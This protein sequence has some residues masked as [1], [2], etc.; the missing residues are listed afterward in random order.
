MKSI[1][2]VSR[3]SHENAE[4]MRDCIDI[5][6]RW[7]C[8]WLI[9]AFLFLPIHVSAQQRSPVKVNEAELSRRAK[10]IDLIVETAESARTFEDF[11]YR[12]RMQALA[13]DALWQHDDVRARAIFRRAWDA[14][15]SYD[16]SEQEIEERESGV[17]S[18]LPITE[19]RDEVLTKV[20]ARDS[21][22]SEEFLRDLINEKKDENDSR[23]KL[24]NQRRTPWRD[25]SAEGQHRL[26]IAYALLNAGETVAAVRTATPL[27]SEGASADLITFLIVLSERDKEE[28]TSLYIRL[29]QRMNNDAQADAI[30]VLL[31]SAPVI[32][33]R[34][35]VT[36]DGQ[37]ALQFRTVPL[38]SPMTTPL[39]LTTPEA[40][41]LF[42]SL[43]ANILLRP[44]AGVMP[45]SEIIARY[46]AIGRLLSYFQRFAPQYETA[47]RIQSGTLGNDIEAGRREVL[48]AQI[49]MIS[50]T[51]ERR[52]DVLRPQMDQLGRARDSADRDRIALGIV[53]KAAQNRL[54]DRARRAAMEIEDINSRRSALSYLAVCQVA[55][56]LRTFTDDKEENVDHL[57]KFVRNSDVPKLVAAWGLA[58]TA[59]MAKRKG[60]TDSAKA[61]VDEAVAFAARTPA[62]TWQR[63]AAYTAVTRLAARIDPAR[64]WEILPE[65][66]R[67]AN[68]MDDYT[69]DERLIDIEV[70]RNDAEEELEP[71]SV[72]DDVFRIDGLF[73]A[74]AQ[75]DYDKALAA[76]RSLG[77]EIP[78]AFT[79][80]A[81][82]KVMLEKGSKTQDSK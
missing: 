77:M 1:D 48:N 74:M 19:A 15:T 20:A 9:L 37:G 70:G 29:L 30:D 71:L 32:S 44:Q 18:E 13:A 25:L 50:L 46:V 64:A 31:Y 14:A 43:S 34:L 49:E 10:A 28:A 65:V 73:S 35:L 55:D 2:M 67:A 8:V 41:N 21:K 42:C 3:H 23:Q 53:K 58:Q 82:A 38:R 66:V 17:P 11:F 81:I 59:I 26:A 51:P 68:A 63:V 7:F 24:Q 45:I 76:S 52:G 60:D 69:G 54:W 5:L 62:A 75:L 78:R 27:I 56:L 72:G 22:L 36:V 33:H 12:A 79:S 6:V 16:K 39:L 61:L 80:L 4:P 57:A 47:L 40:N